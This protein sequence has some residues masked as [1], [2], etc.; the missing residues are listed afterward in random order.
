MGKEVSETGTAAGT[1][2]EPVSPGPSQADVSNVGGV[3]ADDA[4]KIVV[5]D[6]VKADRC[7]IVMMEFTN[8]SQEQLF[9]DVDEYKCYMSDE[10][11][12][13]WRYRQHQD[14]AALWQG[15]RLSPGYYVRSKMSFCS[16]SKRY[17]QGDLLLF[18]ESQSDYGG[19]YPFVA[20][21]KG[22]R[23]GKN[24][25]N[26]TTMSSQ[27]QGGSVAHTNPKPAPPEQAPCFI[28]ASSHL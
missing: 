1:A 16:G 12:E 10:I 11:G 2:T 7:L 26:P 13:K 25:Q 17:P 24:P 14:T 19:R 21:L 3:W 18:V 5:D 28:E 15:R 23:L 22:I 20:V 4:L 9:I 8:T 6:V 27:Q